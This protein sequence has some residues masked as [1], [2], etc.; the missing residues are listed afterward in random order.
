M[1]LKNTIA[2]L[3]VLYNLPRMQIEKKHIPQ[4]VTMQ[5]T[6]PLIFTDR[7]QVAYNKR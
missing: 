6:G 4:T 1:D 2:G 3:E 5:I 7:S